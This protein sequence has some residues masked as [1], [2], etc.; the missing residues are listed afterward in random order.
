MASQR[1]ATG[2]GGTADAA[3]LDRPVDRRRPA[4]PAQSANGMTA[5]PRRSYAEDPQDSYK[6]VLVELQNALVGR[7]A[8]QAGRAP[9]SDARMA[10][11]NVGIPIRQGGLYG[12]CA[13]LTECD[14]P[15]IS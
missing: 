1:R 4:A 14:Q 6:P 8:A 11:R 15:K 12:G 13:G 7:S 5:Q 3:D 2:P 9:H 10:T